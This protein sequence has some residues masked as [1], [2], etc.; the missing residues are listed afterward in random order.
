MDGVCSHSVS[1]LHIAASAKDIRKLLDGNHVLDQRTF[2][3]S[4]EGASVV[5]ICKHTTPFRR[6][7]GA[8][9]IKTIA[10]YQRLRSTYATRILDVV[11]YEY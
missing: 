8:I 2:P 1:L 11:K 10:F 7:S 4:L 9:E 3:L 5:G 6:Q